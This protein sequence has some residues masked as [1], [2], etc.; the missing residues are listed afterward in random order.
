MPWGV[1]HQVTRNL[2]VK[3]KAPLHPNHVFDDRALRE[4]CSTDLLSNTSGLASLHIGSSKLIENQCLSSVYMAEN[5]ENRSSQR[6]GM[7]L[8]LLG[9]HDLLLPSLLLS[10]KLGQLL[11]SLLLGALRLGSPGENIY[12]LGGC[13]HFL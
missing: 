4:E 10:L 7:L 5:T 1:D 8:G 6:G 3:L 9:F 11:L 13:G 12:C 2:Q